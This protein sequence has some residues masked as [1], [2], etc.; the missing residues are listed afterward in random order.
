MVRVPKFSRDVKSTIDYTR[1]PKDVSKLQIVRT[2]KHEGDVSKA[3][4]M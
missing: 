2:F 3:R 4:A 1:L